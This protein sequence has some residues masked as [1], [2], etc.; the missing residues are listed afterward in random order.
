MVCVSDLVAFGALMECQR[1]GWAVPG[2]VA[3]AGFG[4][5]EVAKNCRPRLT[6]VAVDCDAIGRSAGEVLRRAIEAARGGGRLLPETVL[7]PFRIE[8]REST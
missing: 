7:I 5:F 2:R 3:I 6:T 1:R 8:E 4:D